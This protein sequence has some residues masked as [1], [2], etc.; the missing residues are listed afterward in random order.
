MSNLECKAQQQ[1]AYHMFNFAICDSSV[2]FHAEVCNRLGLLSSG[3]SGVWMPLGPALQEN[4]YRAA[5]ASVYIEH[6]VH[7][8]NSAT[9]S[10]IPFRQQ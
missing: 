1:V 3:I 2:A 8:G 6:S 7:M 4:L 10:C 9:C 5:K